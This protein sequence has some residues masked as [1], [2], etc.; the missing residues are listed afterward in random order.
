M[1]NASLACSVSSGSTYAM[2]RDWSTGSS[3]ETSSFAVSASFSFSLHASA[4]S[5][6][7]SGGASESGVRSGRWVP[8]STGPSRTTVRARTPSSRRGSLATVPR[9]GA[10]TRAR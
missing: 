5:A 7:S 1:L 10:R 8:A 4:G 3:S 9:D 6:C 2:V